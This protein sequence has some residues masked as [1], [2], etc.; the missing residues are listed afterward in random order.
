[1][2]E[3][4]HVSQLYYTYITFYNV[5]QTSKSELKLKLW[6]KIYKS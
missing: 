5:I 4:I 2:S 3:H 1:M 6:L